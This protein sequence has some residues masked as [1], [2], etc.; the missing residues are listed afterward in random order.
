MFSGN[1]Q[2]PSDE[3]ENTVEASAESKEVTL[4]QL[5]KELTKADGLADYMFSFFNVPTK[6]SLATTEHVLYDLIEPTLLFPRVLEFIILPTAENIAELKSILINHPD[7]FSKVGD[8]EGPYPCERIIKK[9][10]PFIL[11]LVLGDIELC[12]WMLDTFPDNRQTFIDQYRQFV[13]NGGITYRIKNPE[14]KDE[15]DF[16]IKKSLSIYDDFMQELVSALEKHKTQCE[17][18]NDQDQNPDPSWIE[19][20]KVEIQL[21]VVAAQ[22]LLN[23]RSDNGLINR[24][25]TIGGSQHWFPLNMH[26]FAQF[27]LGDDWSYFITD[28]TAYYVPYGINIDGTT[29]MLKHVALTHMIQ[30]TV[31]VEFIDNL[32]KPSQSLSPTKSS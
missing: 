12:Q 14:S 30:M 29:R 18:R 32:L 4:S 3:T 25:L 10:S 13:E 2:N 27:S 26:D 5:T 19:I 9:V 1:Q 11:A 6:A 28:S 16:L 31:A 22:S 8:A 21:P 20:G 15:N 23:P 24:D 7:L 17:Q